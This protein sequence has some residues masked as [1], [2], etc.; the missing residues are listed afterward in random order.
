MKQKVSL[1]LS[2]GGARGIAHIG[3]IE[4]LKQQ[5][6]EIVSL[7]GTSMGALVGGIYALGKLDEFRNWLFELDKLKIFKL[8]D[9]SFSSQGLIK[10]DRVINELHKFIPDKKI[11]DLKIIYSAVAVDILNKKEVVFKKGSTFEAMRASIAI[12]TVFTPIK[13]ANTLLVDGGVLNNIPINHAKRSHGD[14][15]IAVN[16]NANTP[17]YKPELLKE[18]IETKQSIYLQKIKE[19]HNQMQSII[20]INKNESFDYFNLI[21]KTINLMIEHITMTNIEKYPPDILINVSRQSCGVF[22]F[23]KA[24]EMYEIGRHSAKESLE[25]HN[26]KMNI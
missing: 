17:L 16:V 18:E 7:T 23:Y 1:V 13:K 8:F 15:L 14:L 25:K 24:E 21:S 9:Y 3:V 20:P 12:P 4:E 22:D 10:G 6:F 26:N 19:F 5:N 2:G 11:E